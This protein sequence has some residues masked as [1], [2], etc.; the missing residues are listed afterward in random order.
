[1]H[2]G[3]VGLLSYVPAEH[4]PPD[5]RHCC[6]TDADRPEG[7]EHAVHHDSDNGGGQHDHGRH[8]VD[9]HGVL[10]GTHAEHSRASSGDDA[11]AEDLCGV[12][13]QQ[14]LRR[15]PD[16]AAEHGFTDPVGQDDEYETV[17]RSHGRGQGGELRTQ[18][19][20]LP[21][22]QRSARD[23]RRACCNCRDLEGAE[24]ADQGD[25]SADAAQ[26]RLPGDGTERAGTDKRRPRVG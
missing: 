15:L 9:L 16:G 3:D 7:A 14:R 19:E 24:D 12:G 13:P 18:T 26:G 11:E 4:A 10:G 6:L 1:M 17:E 23:P 21:R 2:H 25:V 8:H 5:D 22:T 20:H